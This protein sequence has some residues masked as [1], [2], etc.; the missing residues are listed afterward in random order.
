MQYTEEPNNE[1]SFVSV[2]DKSYRLGDNGTHDERVLM[3]VQPSPTGTRTADSVPL[4]NGSLV[5][6]WLM[7]RELCSLLVFEP[8]T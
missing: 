6:L 1:G 4:D 7:C 5:R 3:K 8:K 2:N